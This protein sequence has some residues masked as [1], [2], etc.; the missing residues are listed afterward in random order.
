MTTTAEIKCLNRGAS[1]KVEANLKVN[2]IK[3]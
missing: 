2:N 1:A 3:Q